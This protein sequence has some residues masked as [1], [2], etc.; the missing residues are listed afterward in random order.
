MTELLVV[1]PKSLNAADKATLRR[2]GV[3]VVE[4]TE[5]KD[6]RF[7]RPGQD[8]AASDLALAAMNALSKSSN[9]HGEHGLFV[10]LIAQALE[11]DANARQAA[12]EVGS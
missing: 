4:A 1:K 6:V 9:I 8:L 11:R 5:P 3:V 12:G 10:K 7:L 2:A